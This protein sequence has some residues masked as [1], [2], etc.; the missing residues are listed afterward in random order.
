MTS[1][2]DTWTFPQLETGVYDL[3][4]GH[5][6]FDDDETESEQVRPREVGPPFIGRMTR[7]LC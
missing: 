6:S 3:C 1:V 7:T 2:R 5:S 4:D